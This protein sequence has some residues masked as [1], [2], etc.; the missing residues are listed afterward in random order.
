VFVVMA[1]GDVRRGADVQV[2]LIAVTNAFQADWNRT[3]EPLLGER[4]QAEAELRT[5]M[6]AVVRAESERKRA[7]ERAAQTQAA[8]GPEYQQA[9][10]R[11]DAAFEAATQA[12]RAVS[13]ARRRIAEVSSRTTSSLPEIMEKHT[14]RTVRTDVNGRYEVRG[15]PTGKFHVFARQRVF[16]TTVCSFVPV[17]V[18]Q[19][20][21][22]VD[23]SPSNAGCPGDLPKR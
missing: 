12:A 10:A 20:P 5:G 14:T 15:L 2:I 11:E 8:G 6:E 3:I 21:Q 1:S 13:T 19:A 16:S 7:V 22:R 23:L 17:G 9:R 4:Q 18:E